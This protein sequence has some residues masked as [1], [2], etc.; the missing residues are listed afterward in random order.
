MLLYAAGEC[1]AET[2]VQVP[3]YLRQPEWNLKHLARE[4]IRKHPIN[5]DPHENLFGRIPLLGLPSLITEYLLYDMS[6]DDDLTLSDDSD[7]YS[8]DDDDSDDDDSGDDDSDDD[9]GS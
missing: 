1:F 8:D 4:A 2:K 5:I 7:V 9:L 3:D 6:L